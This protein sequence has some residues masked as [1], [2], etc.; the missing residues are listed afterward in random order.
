MGCA[1]PGD[2]GTGR[3]RNTACVAYNDELAGRVRRLVAGEPRLEEKRMFGGLAFLIDGKLAVSA[4]SKG[5][6]LVRVD[7]AETESLAS[8]PLVEPFVMR[9]RAMSGWL[10]VT[11]DAIQTDSDLE[12]W[13]R[14]GV[15]YAS[16]LGGPT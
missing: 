8:L 14:R 12:R 7:P 15:T 11:S 9:G 2:S 6:L 5:G 16:S 13:V 1:R 10:H 4:S 3:R